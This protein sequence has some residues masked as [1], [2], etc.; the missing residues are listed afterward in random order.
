MNPHLCLALGFSHVSFGSGVLGTENIVTYPSVG[1]GLGLVLGVPVPPNNSSAVMTT[2][3]QRREEDRCMNVLV[4]VLASICRRAC[5]F[6]SKLNF[7]DSIE[8]FLL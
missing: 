8:D 5:V 3:T 2:N 6:G 1:V 4:S 7:G